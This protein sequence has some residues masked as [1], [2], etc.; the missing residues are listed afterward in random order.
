MPGVSPGLCPMGSSI[1]PKAGVWSLTPRSR[2]WRTKNLLLR[3][4][5]GSGRP[6]VSGTWNRSR[7]HI[8][9]TNEVQFVLDV[10]AAVTSLV[11]ANALSDITW[12]LAQEFA[13]TILLRHRK[14]WPEN[15]VFVECNA[16]LY[17]CT[18]HDAASCAF[19]GRQTF[20]SFRTVRAYIEMCVRPFESRAAEDTGRPRRLGCFARYRCETNALFALRR[21]SVY[22]FG[23]TGDKTRSLNPL[24]ALNAGCGIHFFYGDKIEIPS[25]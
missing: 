15:T 19:E 22:R 17:V 11:N 21:A 25:A 14:L 6:R 1:C 5:T 16:R 8:P 9:E 18:A 4:M 23:A 24:V 10:N 3:K 2:S 7:G 20:R 13:H 12:R